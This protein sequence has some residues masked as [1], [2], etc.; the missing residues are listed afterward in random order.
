VIDFSH[1]NRRKPAWALASQDFKGLQELR[2]NKTYKKKSARFF[3]K[4]NKKNKT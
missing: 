3:L 1:P 2:F 4:N